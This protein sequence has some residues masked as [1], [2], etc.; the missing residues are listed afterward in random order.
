MGRDQGSDAGGVYRETSKRCGKNRQD[1]MPAC[2]CSSCKEAPQKSCRISQKRANLSRWQNILKYTQENERRRLPGVNSIWRVWRDKDRV[3][4]KQRW[5][6]DAAGIRNPRSRRRI[7]L[8]GPRRTPRPCCDEECGRPCDTLSAPRP[9]RY[10]A[11]SLRLP[12]AS[13]PRATPR[14]TVPQAPR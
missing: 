10:R 9:R 13:L 8:T 1:V 3:C 12:A 5:K 14:R 7:V 4:T 11:P 2:S 6:D